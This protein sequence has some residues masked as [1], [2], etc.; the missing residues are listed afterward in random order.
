MPED[1][2][3]GLTVKTFSSKYIKC[4]CTMPKIKE[5]RDVRES[6]LVSNPRVSYQFFLLSFFSLEVWNEENQYLSTND[7][8]RVLFTGSSAD[9]VRSKQAH[10]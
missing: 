3:F 5:T 9:S 4:T 7:I 10:S 2:I 6:A 1:C 8:L